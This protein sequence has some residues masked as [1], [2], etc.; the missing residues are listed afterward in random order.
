MEW[1]KWLQKASRPAKL[2]RLGNELDRALADFVAGSAQHLDTA[3]TPAE[4]YW[5]HIRAEQLGMQSAS[6]RP[7][8]RLSK[9]VGWVLGPPLP[10][11]KEK[12]KSD[13]RADCICCDQRLSVEAAMYNFDLGGPFCLECIEGDSDLE[14]CKWEPKAS[15]WVDRGP[16]KPK[17][18]VSWPS[19]VLQLSLGDRSVAYFELAARKLTGEIVAVLRCHNDLISRDL[20]KLLLAEMTR[21]NALPEEAHVLKL[22]LPGG[23][24]L[25]PDSTA[26]LLKKLTAY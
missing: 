9:P 14:G 11:A 3:G 8:I 19:L 6:S 24:L 10:T 2:R 20:L 16:K 18:D 25:S 12:R 7:G 4:R 5:L 23:K 15:F 22:V 17:L 26:S 21:T 13:W 1:A